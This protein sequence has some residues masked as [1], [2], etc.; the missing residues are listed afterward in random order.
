MEEKAY[1]WKQSNFHHFG[2]HPRASFVSYIVRSRWNPIILNIC[3]I[4]IF[5]TYPFFFS[6]SISCF[7]GM[8][9]RFCFY[10]VVFVVSWSLLWVSI[11]FREGNWLLLTVELNFYFISIGIRFKIPN[12]SEKMNNFVLVVPLYA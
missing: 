1:R 3:F 12:F 2:I 9:V 5:L 4:L 11:K 7:F 8:T 10:F 6:P